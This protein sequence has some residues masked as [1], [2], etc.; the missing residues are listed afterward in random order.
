MLTNASMCEK[1]FKSILAPGCNLRKAFQFK[2]KRGG[3]ESAGRITSLMQGKCKLSNT[4]LMFDMCNNW[5][6]R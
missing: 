6:I 1:E 3:G 2:S 5:Y 4:G